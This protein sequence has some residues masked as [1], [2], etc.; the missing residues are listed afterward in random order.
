MINQKRQTMKSN[1]QTKKLGE[2][3]D[4]IKGK[5]PKIFV[6]KSSKPYLTAKVI[7][8]TVKPKFAAENCPS[9]VWV[10]KEDIIIIM[11]GSNSGEMFTG[12]E[13]ALAS[14]MGIVKYQ[15]D[16]LT[17][18]YLLHFLITHRENFTKSRTGAAI[19][20]LSKEGFENLEIPIPPFNEQRHIVKILDEV[21]EKV[22]RAKEN[23]EKNLQN[24]KELFESYL[25]NI[26][27]NPS[28]DWEEKSLEEVLQK[29][30]T[31]NPLNNPNKEFIYIDISSVNKENLSIENT[32]LIKGKDAP[33]RARKLVRTGDVIF[34][35]VR[36][37]LRRI[38]IVTKEFN[39]QICS[40]GYFVLRAKENLVNKLVFYFIQTKSFN[41][42][43]EKSQKGTSYP[44]VTDG[45]IKN[46]I[47]SFPKSFSEQKSIVKKLDILSAETKKLEA[48]Y[49]Q[50]LTD[51]EELKKSVLAKAFNAEL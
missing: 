19:P 28:K 20:H 48:I 42:K 41:E 33:S 23:A 49:K 15:K 24:S 7:R 31:I 14:T 12:L 11:D 6:S 35:T 40:T 32:T 47:I 21:F 29:T 27:A 2:I 51:L 10:R 46:Q 18:K 16:L 8:K 38:A 34:A 13:G 1:W 30:E 36:P 37:T 39:E 22:A 3:C 5:K 25:Q 44:A 9:S 50:K 26:F 17:P 4:L 43:M 45:D